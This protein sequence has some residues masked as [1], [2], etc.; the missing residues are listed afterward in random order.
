METSDKYIYKKIIKNDTVALSFS[1]IVESTENDILSK[2][3]LYQLNKIYGDDIC[4]K[5]N[6]IELIKYGN[7]HTQGSN[8]P[9]LLYYEVTISYYYLTP[10]VNSVIKCTINNINEYH[11]TA[12]SSVNP[13]IEII[14]TKKIQNE[15]SSLDLLKNKVIGN[16]IYVTILYSKKNG[17]K[18]SC[19]GYIDPDNAYS[20]DISDNYEFKLL[21]FEIEEYSNELNP[22]YSDTMPVPN[23]EYGDLENLNNVKKHMDKFNYDSYIA[24][25]N[26]IK[27]VIATDNVSEDTQI[28][29]DN[30]EETDEIEEGKAKADENKEKDDETED[31]EDKEKNDEDDE[32]EDEDDETED[33]DKDD[34]DEEDEVEKDEEDEVEDDKKKEKENTNEKDEVNK[35]EEEVIVKRQKT[36]RTVWDNNK[37]MVNRYSDLR[38]F[39][40]KYNMKKVGIISRAY[41]KIREMI[42]EH[43]LLDNKEDKDGLIFASVG[44]GPGGFISS[45]ID[46]RRLTQ[47]AHMDELHDEYY[48]ITISSR[49]KNSS[50]NWNRQYFDIEHNTNI[51]KSKNIY[52]TGGIIEDDNDIGNIINI[53]NIKNFINTLNGKKCHLITADGGISAES[54]TYEIRS[55]NNGKLYMSEIIIAIAIQEIGGNFVIKFDDI[56]HEIIVDLLVILQIH[57]KYVNIHKPKTSRPMSSEKYVICKDFRGLES[58]SNVNYMDRYFD[59]LS[60]WIKEENLDTNYRK[61]NKYIVRLFNENVGRSIETISSIKI[62]NNYIVNTQTQMIKQTLEYSKLFE[63]IYINKTVPEIKWVITNNL[64]NDDDNYYFNLWLN[65]YEFYD[66]YPGKLKTKNWIQSISYF[67]YTSIIKIINKLAQTNNAYGNALKDILNENIFKNIEKILTKQKI[68]NKDNINKINENIGKN[69]QLPT[70]ESLKLTNKLKRN[71]MLKVLHNSDKYRDLVLSNTEVLHTLNNIIGFSPKSIVDIGVSEDQ[72]LTSRLVEY[73]NIP[74]N[75]A[76]GV[77]VAN[78]KHSENINFRFI[79][80]KNNEIP[81]IRDNSIE[82]ITCFMTIHHF[83]AHHEMFKEFKRI[84]KPTGFLIIREHDVTDD[85]KQLEIFSPY[86]KNIENNKKIYTKDLMIEELNLKHKMYDDHSP[87]NYFSKRDLKLKLKRYDFHHIDDVWQVSTQKSNKFGVY[88]SIFVYIPTKK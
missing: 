78:L 62:A 66:L 8:I 53:D 57:Y 72:D 5:P 35:K 14:I 75:K 36:N 87:V 38:A 82:L 52:L 19:C 58:D 59:L 77:D 32:T 51:F 20:S 50:I 84:I 67:K 29:D 34:D 63:N 6:S 2:K 69:E 76:F 41:Y 17:N 39:S 85:K 44:E 47:C 74:K 71:I 1:E 79:L 21:D 9:I 30:E 25:N 56:Y 80:S 31:K 37:D 24:I 60:K 18:I 42:Y 64:I 28:K 49:D 81:V 46:Y 33:K 11:Y 12:K 16:I 13:N 7:A 65:K 61:L 88:F 10:L 48:G 86:K 73:F 26:G 40:G 22:Q 45:I 23:Y 68:L 3:L 83:T 15:H 43:K 54:E 70:N 4:I 55:I 27:Q